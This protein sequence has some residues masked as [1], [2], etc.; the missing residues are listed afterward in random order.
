V[1][2]DRIEADDPRRLRIVDAVEE[3]QVDAGG[4]LRE[5]AE[6]DAVGRNRRA[7]WAAPR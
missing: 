5:D 3:E 1:V 7:E 2:R 4:A 6:V